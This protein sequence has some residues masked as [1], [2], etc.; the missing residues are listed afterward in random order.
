MPDIVLIDC[1][2]CG[3]P[4]IS[5]LG[6]YCMNCFKYADTEEAKKIKEDYEKDKKVLDDIR[7]R[8]EQLSLDKAKAEGKG[9][10]GSSKK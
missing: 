3:H 1:V 10:Q 4:Y 7:H 2:V 9:T 5:G 6:S 8:A